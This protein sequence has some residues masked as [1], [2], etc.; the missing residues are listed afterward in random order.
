MELLYIYQTTSSFTDLLILLAIL[1]TAG[2]VGVGIISAFDNKNS[3]FMIMLL[4]ITIVSIMLAVQQKP[5]IVEVYKVDE[6]KVLQ[7]SLSKYDIYSSDNVIYK[8]VEKNQK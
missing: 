6:P 1:S 3:R 7:E 2:L 5:V 8:L 4:S